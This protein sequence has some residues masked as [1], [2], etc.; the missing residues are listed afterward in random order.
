MNDGEQIYFLMFKK[1]IIF[2]NDAHLVC[3]SLVLA[4]KPVPYLCYNNL[5]IVLLEFNE[6]NVHYMTLNLTYPS[7]ISVS[8]FFVGHVTNTN[9][10]YRGIDEK[11]HNL[12]EI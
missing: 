9:K 3:G 7:L 4:I 1:G 10:Y 8:A 5:L 11:S 6:L 12:K 2:H